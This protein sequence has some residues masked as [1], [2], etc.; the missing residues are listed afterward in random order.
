MDSMI[1]HGIEHYKNVILMLGEIAQPVFCS[2][3]PII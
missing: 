1:G 3:K 2:G